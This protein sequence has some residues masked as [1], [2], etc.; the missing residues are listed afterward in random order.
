M[1]RGPGWKTL[2]HQHKTEHLIKKK[3]KIGCVINGENKLFGV[4]ILKV[5]ANYFARK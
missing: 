5:R 3:K 4:N 2:S 1:W